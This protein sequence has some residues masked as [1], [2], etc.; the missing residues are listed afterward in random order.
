MFGSIEEQSQK[1]NN[2]ARGYSYKNFSMIISSTVNIKILTAR[3][4]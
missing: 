1:F 3:C 4:L 2:N